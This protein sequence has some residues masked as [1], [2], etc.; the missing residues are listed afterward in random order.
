MIKPATR[1]NAPCC[2]VFAIHL[3]NDETDFQTTF[4]ETR[5][6]LGRTKGWQGRMAW[7]EFKLILEA[8]GVQFEA[9]DDPRGLTIGAAEKLGHFSGGRQYIV[10][11][12]GHFLTVRNGL[13]YDQGNPIGVPV[14][15]YFA[16]LRRVKYALKIL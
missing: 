6:E 11:I 2:G 14:G 3:A 8:Y 16:R 1:I 10:F 5:E 9:H 15:R 4:D 7:S 12:S 13:A